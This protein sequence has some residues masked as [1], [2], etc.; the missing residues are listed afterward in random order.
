MNLPLS[1]HA[2]GEH[3]LVLPPDDPTSHD[4][5]R[6]NPQWIGD[7]AYFPETYGS[8]AVPAIIDAINGVT[9]PKNLLV[10]HEII[11]K[12]NIDEYYPNGG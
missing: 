2:Y 7:V 4:D 3:E 9:L 5:I 1:N 10:N 12:D 6:N 8:I 11:T